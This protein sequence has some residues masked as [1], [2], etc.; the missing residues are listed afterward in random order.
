MKVAELIEALSE[1]PPDV[2]VMV[3]GEGGRLLPLSGTVG[4]EMVFAHEIPVIG[5][6][7]VVGI[8]LAIPCIPPQTVV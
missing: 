6:D 4:L 3:V 7:E 1:M 5:E 8:P 2:V